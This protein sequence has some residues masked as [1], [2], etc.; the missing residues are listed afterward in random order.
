L[1]ISPMFI[2]LFLIVVFLA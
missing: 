2:L 1:G